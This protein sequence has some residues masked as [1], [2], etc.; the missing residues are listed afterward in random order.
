M[1]SQVN[2]G[3]KGNHTCECGREWYLSKRKEPMRD[4][5]EISCYC[6]AT[7]VGWNGGCVWTATLVKDI[8]KLP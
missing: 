6:G 7:L 1:S 5:D 2:A 8:P 4:K 3:K